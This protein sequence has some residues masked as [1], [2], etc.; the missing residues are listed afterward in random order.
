M[1]LVCAFV[2]AYANCWFSD[3]AA[4]IIKLLFVYGECGG[5]VVE[6]HFTDLEVMGLKPTGF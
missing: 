3:V 1:K 6:Y 5:L 2:F 4:L